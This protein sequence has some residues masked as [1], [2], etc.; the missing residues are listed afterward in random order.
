MNE[1]LHD[2]FT[3][4]EQFLEAYPCCARAAAV[5][6]RHDWELNPKCNAVSRQRRDSLLQAG[7]LLNLSFDAAAVYHGEDGFSS[8]RI[9]L[10]SSRRTVTVRITEKDGSLLAEKIAEKRWPA[11]PRA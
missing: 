7:Q 5:L 8:V 10:R 4:E 3:E 6:M 11:P 1:H 9:V 2:Y